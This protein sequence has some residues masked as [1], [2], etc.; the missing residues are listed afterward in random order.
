MRA[1]LLV[2]LWLSCCVGCATRREASGCGCYSLG[3]GGV[4]L[5]SVTQVKDSPART[6][7]YPFPAFLPTYPCEMVRAGIL[8]EVTVRV[9]AG[10]DGLVKDAV[11]TNSSQREFEPA[12]LAAI[13]SWQ[14]G[15]VL[16]VSC[17][18]YKGQILD[19]VFQFSIE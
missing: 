2:S 12:V 9:T 8:G 14:F 15:E 13:K 10:K 7:G 6:I 3:G 1:L 11:V 16:E 17:T 19:C 5:A 4:T 18:E